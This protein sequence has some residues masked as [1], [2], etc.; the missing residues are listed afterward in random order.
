MKFIPRYLCSLE[1]FGL[2]LGRIRVSGHVA[3]G[4]HPMAMDPVW[5]RL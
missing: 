2:A 1:A 3:A 4:L 5:V